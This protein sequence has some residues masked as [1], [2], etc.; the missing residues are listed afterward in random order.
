[1]RARFLIASALAITAAA[2]GCKPSAE[3][4]PPEPGGSDAA[5][6]AARDE[7]PADDKRDTIVMIIDESASALSIRSAKRVSSGRIGRSARWNG[8]GPVT[9]RYRLIDASGA[10]LAEGDVAVRR[11]L[12]VAPGGAGGGAHPAGH[13]AARTAFVVRAPAP[14]DGER[15]EI[16]AVDDERMMVIWP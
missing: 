14:R 7:P 12:H 1:M 6:I 16:K 13:A 5:P 3:G 2:A 4:P 10:V 11:D 9:H 8:K 15:I